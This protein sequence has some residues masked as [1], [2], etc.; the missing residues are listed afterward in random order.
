MKIG[1]NGVGTN[2]P[3]GVNMVDTYPN[4]VAKKLNLEGNF[5]GHC[6]RRSSATILADSGA[7]LLT[8]KRHSRWSSV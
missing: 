1:K 5:S 3:T 7:D 6:F 2:R 4:I 8:L